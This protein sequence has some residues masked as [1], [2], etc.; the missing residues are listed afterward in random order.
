MSA[1]CNTD[2]CLS[3]KLRDTGWI[4]TFCADKIG[5]WSLFVTYLVCHP[6]SSISNLISIGLML[7]FAGEK[8]GGRFHC[9]DE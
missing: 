8:N 9:D 2:V 3:I 4:M 6:I 7:S 5:I 1:L